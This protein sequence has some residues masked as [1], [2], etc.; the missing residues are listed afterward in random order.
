MQDYRHNLYKHYEAV[1]V[2]RFDE[3][4]SMIYWQQA[5]ILQQSIEK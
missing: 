5:D 1:L 4:S 2:T 3:A